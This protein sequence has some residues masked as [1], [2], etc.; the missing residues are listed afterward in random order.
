MFWIYRKKKMMRA[1]L[2]KCSKFEKI[3]YQYYFIEHQAVEKS[4]KII[5]SSQPKKIYNAI[6]RI[7]EKNIKICYNK[8]I[9]LTMS[10]ISV[11]IHLL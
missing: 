9:V 2:E 7:K 11:K 3:V 1:I 6:F 5:V 8:L 4:Q 10:F